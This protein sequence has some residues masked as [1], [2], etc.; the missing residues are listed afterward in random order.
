MKKAI[1]LFFIIFI[2]TNSFSQVGIGTNNPNAT[3]EV[4]GEPSE[5]GVSDG[6]IAPRISRADLIA[7][8]GY[9]VSQTGAIVYITDLSGT[10]NTASQNIT[11]IGYYYFN[12]TSWKSMNSSGFKFIFGDTK[13]G[14]QSTDHSGWIKLDGRLISTLSSTQ[15]TKAIALG[16]NTNLP[17]ATNAYLSQNGLTIGSVTGNNTKTIAQ[18][19]L[20]NVA[21]TILIN[22]AGDHSHAF[23]ISSNGSTGGGTRAVFNIT[24]V[25][26]NNPNLGAGPTASAGNHTHTA[27]VTSINGGVA[28]VQLDITPKSL[29]VNTFIYLGE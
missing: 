12:G 3:L 16:F 4:V 14:F 15:Q 2:Y 9:S 19:N 18:N 26:D 28:Q 10:V 20:P 8:T 27:T 17:D 1:I 29:S 13:Q 23:S 22:N 6:I 24:G 5:V 7:K 21:P 25:T 11:E